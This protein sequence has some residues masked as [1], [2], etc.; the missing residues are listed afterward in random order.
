MEQIG[1][2]PVEHRHKVVAD[3][4]D[5]L[6]SQVAQ[7]LLIYLYLVVAIGTAVLDCLNYWQTFDHAPAH[8]VTLDVLAQVANLLAGPYL[9]QR[10]IVQ[11]GNNTFNSDLSQLC[12][13]NLILLAKPSPCSFHTYT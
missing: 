10:Y 3:A 11:S 4:V 8:A 2:S 13:S 6:G 12:K 5:A 1:T 7:A 9:A